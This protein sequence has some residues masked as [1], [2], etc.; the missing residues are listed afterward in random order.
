VLFLEPWSDIYTTD[1]ERIMSFEET[2]SFSEALSDVYTR[3]GY[4][5]VQ[6]PQKSIDG[7]VAYVRE[8]VS[9]LR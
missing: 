5:L 2:T 6:V 9:T 1:E 3:S 4:T 7:R 8:F